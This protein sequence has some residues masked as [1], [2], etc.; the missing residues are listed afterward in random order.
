MLGPY[1]QAVD[2][3][4]Q[5][6]KG[7]SYTLSD[8]LKSRPVALIFGMYTCPAFQV[9]SASHITQIGH[10]VDRRISDLLIEPRLSML[11]QG[12]EE[13][14]TTFAGSGHLGEYEITDRFQNSF[15]FLHVYGR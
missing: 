10:P 7:A 14:G 6:I 9:T 13:G 1:D 4:L 3:T 15:H 11:G 8:L 12:L 2:F 5:D